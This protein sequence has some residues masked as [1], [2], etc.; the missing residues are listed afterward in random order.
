M[1]VHAMTTIDHV[2]DADFTEVVLRA[3]VPVLVD[4]WAPWCGPC[5]QVA[6]ILEQ[7]A[8]EN[9]GRLRI[10]KLN[11]DENPVTASDYRITGMP[12]MNVY[13]GGEVVRQIR[14]ARPRA[15]LLKELDGFVG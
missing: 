12:T 6:P 9:E 13:V 14:G 2:T 10:V 8:S 4:F 15:A 11:V 7:I 1:K 5:L 3:P